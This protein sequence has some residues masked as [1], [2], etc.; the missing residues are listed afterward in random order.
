MKRYIVVQLVHVSEQC[1]VKSKDNRRVR[2]FACFDAKKTDTA[3]TPRSRARRPVPSVIL[4]ASNI[5]LRYVLE[6]VNM[7]DHA[8]GDEYTRTVDSNRAVNR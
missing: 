7:A 8:P 1:H 4:P 6:F 3:R 5:I 2:R